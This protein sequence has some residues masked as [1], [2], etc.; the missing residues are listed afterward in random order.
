MEFV[1]CIFAAILVGKV[2]SK[3]GNGVMRKLRRQRVS[4]DVRGMVFAVKSCLPS[5]EIN[6]VVT[7]SF[8]CL[9]ICREACVVPIKIGQE[10]K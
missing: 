7:L 5:E 3:R 6:F 1:V 4:S 8:V 9:V 10:V 2:V